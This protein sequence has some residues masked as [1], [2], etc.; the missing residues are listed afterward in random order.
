VT[1]TDNSDWLLIKGPTPSAFTGPS[2]DHTTNSSNGYYIYYEANN[3]TNGD[4][5]QIQVWWAKLILRTF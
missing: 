3:K 2:N 5:A 1:G 4:K